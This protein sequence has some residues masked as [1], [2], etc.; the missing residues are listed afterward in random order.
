MSQ[1]RILEPASAQ[2]PS[3]PRL[4]RSLRLVTELLA[5]RLANAN[6]ADTSHWDETD[7]RIAPAVAAMHGIA[8]LLSRQSWRGALPAWQQFLD[9]QRQHTAA[10][11]QRLVCLLERL[12]EAARGLKLT[13]LALTGVALHNLGIYE[14]GTR[15]MADIDSIRAAYQATEPA[16]EPAA[17]LIGSKA[18]F[19]TASQGDGIPP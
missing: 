18:C 4:Q 9:E 5:Q 13:A 7:W 19:Y 2:L 17:A 1:S 15:P 8:P 10:R 12:N 14:P 11:H 16:A 3:L 6:A